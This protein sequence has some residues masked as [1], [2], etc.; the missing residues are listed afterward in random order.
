MKPRAAMLYRLRRGAVLLLFFFIAAALALPVTAHGEG[1]EVRIGWYETPFNIIDKSGRRS[2]YAYEYQQKLAA[3]SGWNFTY[4]KGSWSELME[5]LINGEIDMMSDISYT[6]ERAEKI[7]FPDLPMG[8]EEYCIFVAPGNRD[9]T[10]KDYSTLNGKRI[11]VYR[12][13]VHA[14]IFLRWA[15]LHGIQAELVEL[16]CTEAEALDMLDAGKL[17]AY[18]TPNAYADPARLVPVCRIG[19][20]DIFVAVNKNRP[21]LLEDLNAAM[22]RIQ[23]E[24]PYF[25]QAMFAKYAQRYGTNAF[26]TSEETSWLS[27]HGA[28]RVG[29]QDNYLAFCARD[30]ATG[31]LTG[32]LK[33]YLEAASGCLKG[34]HLDFEASAFP[35]AAAALDALA[36]GEVDCVFP[37]NLGSFDGEKMGIVMT[38]PMIRTDVYAVVRQK[39]RNRFAGKEHVIVA[40]TEDNP[41]YDVFLLDNFPGW[42]KVY[43]ADTSECLKAVAEGVADCVLVGSYRYNNISRQCERYRLTTFAA[44]SGMDYCFAVRKGESELYSILAKAVGLVPNAKVNEALSYYIAEDSRRSFSDFIVDNLSIVMAGTGVILLVILLLLARSIQAEKRAKMLIAATETDE[45][46]G[47]YNRDYFFQYANRMYRGHPETPMDAI[48]VNIE[49][50]H[51]VNALNGWEFGDRVLRFLG[52]EIRD[53]LSEVS[54]IAGRFGADRFDIYCRHTE[55]YRNIFDRLQST[56]D[57]LAPNASIRLRMGVMPWQ[58]KLEP[59]QLFDRARTAC[60]MA[61]GHY[62]NHLVVFGEKVREREL[63]DQRL[64]NDLRRALDNYEFEVHYQPKYNIQVEPPKLVSA[65]ALIR[66]RHPELG[67]L[68]PDAFIPLFERNGKI[69][70]VDKYVWSKAARQIA[71]WQAQYGVM[72]PISVNLSRVDVFDLTLE[73]T[74]D[75]ILAQNGLGYDALKL[76]VTE[77]AYTEKADRVIQVVERLRKK[78]YTVEMDD[79]GIGYSSLNM[80]S[81]MPVDVLKM[82]RTFIRNIERDDKDVQL[83]SLILGIAKNM[84]IS[85]IAEGVETEQ[86][87]RL[88]KK[89]GCVLAQ[90]YFFSRP[91]HP[92]EFEAQILRKLATNPTAENPAQDT[93]GSN[94]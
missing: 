70:E 74:L 89:L 6:D 1:K 62:K 52:S 82:D 72:I 28:I 60:S 78:G 48:V 14:D 80:L 75:G 20:S 86:Q 54:G 30:P 81:S 88:L 49:Q 22:R 16:V 35:T 76:E 11:G 45:L 53:V 50:F 34:V 55:D 8:V 33:D 79:F 87:L 31:E 90:G 15:A 21:D 26:L 29:Y 85:A 10:S 65:E 18:V 66:W 2:G 17:D 77:S 25:N 91:L 38:P 39:D 64:L 44:G 47:L 84:N 57:A 46:T 69:G 36:R 83:V 92:S 12:N 56:I 37:A 9:I 5:M 67:M 4:V 24:N 58:S 32:A 61:R 13:S 19:S 51:S 3:Y 63:L 41:N 43:Y 68:S 59:V 40:V 94:E 71:Q 27:S 23:D 7:L 73:E 93:I 42:R